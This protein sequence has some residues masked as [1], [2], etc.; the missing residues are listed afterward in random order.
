MSTAG[1]MLVLDQL[2]STLQARGHKVLLF[3]QMTKVLDILE[4]FLTMRPQY[5]YRRLDGSV[6][7]GLLSLIFWLF[8]LVL[9]MIKLTSL[10]KII[11]LST[12]Y[13]PRTLF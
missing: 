13:C 10:K 3:S 5:Q 11:L 1:K 6:S 2:L 9:M 12:L 4:D 7:T 8:D